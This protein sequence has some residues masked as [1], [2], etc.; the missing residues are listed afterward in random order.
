MAGAGWCSAT[1]PLT[2]YTPL[3]QAR[4]AALLSEG[5]G[6]RLAAQVL[7]DFRR[8]FPKP[9]ANP[10][11][12]HLYRAEP[13]D[14]DLGV[15]HLQR[16]AARR[17]LERVFFGEHRLARPVSSTDDGID[18]THRAVE[19]VKRLSAGRKP[20]EIVYNIKLH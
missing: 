17:W 15:A 10:V 11:E 4:R 14:D 6:R 16:S 13:S 9:N 7:S 12:V 20:G 2:C 1:N 19:D 3:P 18:T 8:L 5:G